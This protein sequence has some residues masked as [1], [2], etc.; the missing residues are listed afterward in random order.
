[1]NKNETWA[2]FFFYF[3]TWTRFR[4]TVFEWVILIGFLIPKNTWR[5]KGVVV[6]ILA[7]LGGTMCKVDILCD[8]FGRNK[9]STII[10]TFSSFYCPHAFYWLYFWLYFWLYLKIVYFKK[11]CSDYWLTY[12]W[13]L[14]RL[15]LHAVF[16]SSCW[17]LFIMLIP[18]YL[19]NP[20]IPSQ[21][22]H[23]NSSS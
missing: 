5:Q 15:S 17:F 8:A 12:D 20:L 14:F 21:L 3:C 7:S 4:N 19:D 23:N 11:N 10:M 18:I 22:H 6:W 13:S 1:M 2:R 16:F 9:F